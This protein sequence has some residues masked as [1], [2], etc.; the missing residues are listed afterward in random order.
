MAFIDYTDVD[1][2]TVA[3]NTLQGFKLSATETLSV[4]FA[5]K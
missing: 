1:K 4:N 2:A 3:K 5:K